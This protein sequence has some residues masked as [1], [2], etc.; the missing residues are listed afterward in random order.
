MRGR[1]TLALV[2][3]FGLSACGR[4]VTPPSQRTVAQAPGAAA[5]AAAERASAPET[6]DRLRRQVAFPI[7]VPTLVPDGLQAGTPWQKPE[8]SPIVHVPYVSEDGKQGLSVANGPSGSGLDADARKTGKS[9]KIRDNITAH[10]LVNQPGFGGSILWW[11]EA[12]AYVAISGPYLT[13]EDLVKIANSMSPDAVPSAGATPDTGHDGEGIPQPTP[14]RYVL[15]TFQG[16]DT[17]GTDAWIILTTLPALN[18]SAY[19]RQSGGRTMELLDWLDNRSADDETELAN[20]LKATTG[21]DGAYAEKYSIVLGTLLSEDPAR[22]AGA[23]GT[24]PADRADRAISLVG[25]YASYERRNMAPAREQLTNLLTSS[26]L[27]EPAR[28][29]TEQLLRAL[30][31]KS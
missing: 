13:E 31:P 22:F 10:F 23:L 25:Y 6:I 5:P 18:W 4:A 29:R 17:S 16:E 8:S 20:I 21:L 27:S 15:K 2:L 26:H 7:L 28:S 19:D 1:L 11:N 12:G 14:E 30:Q 9:T 24:V 3:A